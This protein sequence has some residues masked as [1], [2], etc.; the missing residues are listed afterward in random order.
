MPRYTSFLF[1]RVLVGNKT[2]WHDG[3]PVRAFVS[4]AVLQLFWKSPFC[5][6]FAG[7]HNGSKEQSN[8]FVDNLRA[9]R[10]FRFTELRWGRS[11]N[12]DNTLGFSDQPCGVNSK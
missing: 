10:G 6:F 3:V 5:F 4:E 7:E 2:H 9:E 1:H 8:M 11:W 12:T